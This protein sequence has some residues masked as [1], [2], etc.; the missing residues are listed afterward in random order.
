MGGARKAIEA[1]Y[2]QGEI[3]D[4]AYAALL[5]IESGDQ[6]VVGVNKF[7]DAHGVVPADLLRMDQALQAEQ[8]AR[9]QALR[10]RRDAAQV[11]GVSGPHPR[12]CPG[13]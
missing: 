7:Q 2:I 5:A 11:A 9:V 13:A 6:V 4:A 1:G 3:H 12:G 8:V 10:A